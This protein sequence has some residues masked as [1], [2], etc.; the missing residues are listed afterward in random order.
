MLYEL[1]GYRTKAYDRS[2]DRKIQIQPRRNLG[3]NRIEDWIAAYLAEFPDGKVIVTSVE[4]RWKH[5]EKRL[6]KTVTNAENQL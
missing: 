4:K 3:F 1:H 6:V 5:T 2:S